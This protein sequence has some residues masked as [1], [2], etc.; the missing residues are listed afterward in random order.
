RLT[1]V[2][3]LD[4]PVMDAVVIEESPDNGLG[5][6]VLCILK[7]QT[8]H[9]RSAG[10]FFA[11]IAVFYGDAVFGWYLQAR[12]GE[13]VHVGRGLILRNIVLADHRLKIAGHFMKSEAVSNL[14]AACSGCY[15]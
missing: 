1:R 3:S 15:C 7:T 6:F 12:S 10:G 14:I 9:S 4:Q 8:A 5:R 2:Q 13:L 11:V